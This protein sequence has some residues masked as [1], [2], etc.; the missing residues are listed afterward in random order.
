MGLFA[1][2]TYREIEAP[3]IYVKDDDNDVDDEA[4]SIDIEAV[5]CVD[6]KQKYFFASYELKDARM[7]DN[8]DYDEMLEKLEST[9]DMTVKI[10]L[11]YKGEKLKGFEFDLQSLAT[12]LNDDRFLEIEQLMNWIDDISALQ[13][14][15]NKIK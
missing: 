7:Y 15:R 6:G 2:T 4:G 10:V 8:G 14:I 12:S 13:M 3:F 5:S 11:K 1:K 9:K